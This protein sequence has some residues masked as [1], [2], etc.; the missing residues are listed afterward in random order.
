MP[1]S[2]AVPAPE[3][4]PRQSR[5][6]ADRWKH[7]E[8]LESGYLVVPTA[9]L[10]HYSRLKPHPL[11]RGEALF[12]LHLMEF[13]WDQAAPFPSYETLAERM[14]IS[15]KMARRYARALEQKGCLHRIIRV[16][17]TNRFDLEPL[18]DKLLRTAQG[19]VRA[20]EQGG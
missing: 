17:N 15:T 18:F 11:T 12:V 8:L 2:T 13:K 3:D 14:G 9:F 6:Y 10:R 4:L 7:S 19:N 16:G 20:G 1:F 5:T